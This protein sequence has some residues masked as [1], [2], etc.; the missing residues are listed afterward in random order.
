MATDLTQLVQNRVEADQVYRLTCEIGNLH[1][2]QGRNEG[3]TPLSHQAVDETRD[4]TKTEG[5]PSG[6]KA[7]PQRRQ[8][9]RKTNVTREI[10]TYFFERNGKPDSILLE[11]GGP[12]GLFAKAMRD[13]VVAK[14]K[15]DYWLPSMALITFRAVDDTLD[16]DR[17]YIEVK[18]EC[19]IDS[20][21]PGCGVGV[22]KVRKEIPR[23]EPR[24]S[25]GSQRTMVPVFHERL[26]KPIKIIVEMIVN[27]EC[28]R[29]A[30]E[31]AGL[32]WAMQGVPFGPAKR[33]VLKIISMKRV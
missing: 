17:R 22:T 4:T 15:G 13:A 25:R 18:A 32:L 33:G 20:R 10:Q 27:A 8:R 3:L 24:N 2:V 11:V 9:G 29:T 21:F 19:T 6:E 5:V 14:G 16:P 12:Y 31:V 7:T 30:E 1:A 26:L 23:M 28:P